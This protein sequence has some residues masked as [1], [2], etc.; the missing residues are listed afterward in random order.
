MSDSDN[1]EAGENEIFTIELTM[2]ELEKLAGGNYSADP[3]DAHP[4]TPH[5]TPL[6]S[7]AHPGTPHNLP[8]GK[9]DVIQIVIPG[10]DGKTITKQITQKKNK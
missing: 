1:N 3:K 10:G 5:D 2:E 6:S 4:A 8:A 7:D 9:P